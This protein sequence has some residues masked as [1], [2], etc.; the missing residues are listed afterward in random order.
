M[1]TKSIE[2]LKT[3]MLTKHQEAEKAAYEYFCECEVG[4][5]RIRAGEIYNNI[6][7]AIRVPL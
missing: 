4:P 1:S 3:E 7:I 6:R 2:E 5:E